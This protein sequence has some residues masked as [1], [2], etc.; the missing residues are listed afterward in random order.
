MDLKPSTDVK[1]IGF[2]LLRQANKLGKSDDP[3][4]G[5]VVETPTNHSIM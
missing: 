5:F 2:R 1:L 3:L 4:N